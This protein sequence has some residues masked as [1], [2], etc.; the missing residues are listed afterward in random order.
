MPAVIRTMLNAVRWWALGRQTNA[1]T[2]HGA[3]MGMLG[4]GESNT[5]HSTV[6]SVVSLLNFLPK[7]KAYKLPTFFVRLSKEHIKYSGI[8]K[9]P[10]KN[11]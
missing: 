7:P 8:T 10:I 1:L 9:L 5:I 2:F 6:Q 3:T 11:L 4:S